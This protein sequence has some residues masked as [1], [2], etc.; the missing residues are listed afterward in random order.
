MRSEDLFD[1]H[2][3]SFGS[4]RDFQM[5]AAPGQMTIDTATKA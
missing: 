4:M 2:V 5:I 3:L 1:A